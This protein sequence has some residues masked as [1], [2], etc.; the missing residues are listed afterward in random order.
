MATISS[1]GLGSGLDINAI[2]SQLMAIERQPLNRLEQKRQGFEAQLSAYGTLKSALD[3][4]RSAMGGLDSPDDFKLYTAS[5]SDETI[6]TATAS[7][8]ASVGV[9]DIQVNNL[10]EAHKMGSQSYADKDTTTVGN[11]GDTVTITI[12]SQS[13]TVAIGGK[14]LEQIRDAI[15]TASDALA[16]DSNATNDVDVTASIVQENSSSYYLTLTSDNT[17]TTYAMSLAFKDS[18]GAAITDPLGMATIN[19][20]EDSSLVIDGTYTIT[21]SSNTVSDAIEGVTLNL[22]KEDTVNTYSLTVDRDISGV[23]DKVQSFVDAYNDLKKTIDDL[24]AGDLA[25]D[26]TLLDIQRRLFNEINTTPSGISSAYSYLG[27]VGVTIQKDGTMKLDGDALTLKTALET[28]FNGVAELF[29]NNDQ[30]YAYRL[31][32]LG[33]DFLEIGGQ[34]VIETREDGINDRISAID[35]RIDSM[36]RRLALTEQRLREQFSA[37]DALVGQLQSTSSFLTSQL[38][39]LR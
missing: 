2:V 4:F 35:T 25:G 19:A 22:L 17:G 34:G 15:N 5:S 32:A 26:N 8:T 39:G 33:D 38:S 10:A 20:A 13:M 12:N 23:T 21:R 18:G 37:L 3:S 6:F 1:P 36:G 29:G 11:S 24:R 9:Y 7:S 28:D 31:K 30:G 16:A 14:T 27:E